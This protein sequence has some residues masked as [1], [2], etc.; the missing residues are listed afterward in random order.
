[1]PPTPTSSAPLAVTA[2]AGYGKPDVW[3]DRSL[4]VT[5]WGGV[6]EDAQ[7]QAIFEPFQRLT[8]ARI[9]TE[10][11]DT[12]ELR[13]QVE[14]GDTS[15][16][17]CDVLAEDMLPLA[18]IGVLEELDFNIID[19]ENV[20]DD[21]Q[22]D[23]GVASSFYSTVMAYR[24][25]SWPELPAPSSWADFW[26]AAR[27]PGLRGLR[28]DPR[29]TLE[30]A[31]LADGV[32]RDQLYP[33]DVERAFASLERVRPAVSLWWEQG[34]QP[35]QSLNGG[36]LATVSAWHNRILKIQ[37]EGAPVNF[38][39]ND[40]ALGGDVWV[41]PKG[42]KNRDVAMDLINFATRPETTAAFASL[43]PFG[44]V[45]K[46][47]FEYLPADV[48]NIP[49]SPQLKAQQFTVDL[50]WWFKHREQVSQRFDDWFAEHP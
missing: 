6:Y 11:T 8:G 19:L 12:L 10:A 45:N 14:D 37:G 27:Y 32:V 1:V 35:A 41:V 18:N 24:D 36:G 26:D 46:K 50:E 7:Q 9:Q 40:G 39:W 5:S 3:K 28:R 49:T 30:F 22:S 2:V 13:K 38:I 15:W 21:V 47:A 33:L 25:D 42:S 31:L 16:D 34:A 4:V 43:A 44:P 17:V 20:F 29:T 23:Y 48:A